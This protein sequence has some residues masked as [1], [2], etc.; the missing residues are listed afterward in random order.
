MMVFPT[1]QNKL[2]QEVSKLWPPGQIQQQLVLVNKI[3]LAHNYT[4]SFAYC[5]QTVLATTDCVLATT[6]EVRPAEETSGGENTWHTAQNISQPTPQ[7]FKKGLLSP[8]LEDQKPRK[9]L[10]DIWVWGWG[11]GSHIQ[12]HCEFNFR[13]KTLSK[14]IYLCF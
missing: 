1:N 10:R 12:S 7:P 3:L 14:Y 13:R 6:T 4:H 2:E 11:A 8:D 5:L 9:V